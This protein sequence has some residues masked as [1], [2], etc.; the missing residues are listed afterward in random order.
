MYKILRESP[1]ERKK[2]AAYAYKKR[3]EED[4]KPRIFDART[5]LIGVSLIHLF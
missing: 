5:R 4:R 1:D 3:Y 2:E